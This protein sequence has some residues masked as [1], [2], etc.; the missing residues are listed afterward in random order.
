LGYVYDDFLY[1]KKNE[2]RSSKVVFDE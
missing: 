2:F 1:E